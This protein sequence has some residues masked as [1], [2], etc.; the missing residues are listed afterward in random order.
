MPVKVEVAVQE[1]ANLGANGIEISNFE[2][3]SES[4]TFGLQGVDAFR[5][6]DENGEPTGQEW[7]KYTRSVYAKEKKERD[8]KAEKEHRRLQ[9]GEGGIVNLKEGSI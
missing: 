5:R 7:V 6:L 1:C 2:D 8:K 3:T 4:A 9:K